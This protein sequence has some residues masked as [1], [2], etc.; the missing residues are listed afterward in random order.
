MSEFLRQF[1]LQIRYVSE[2]I[3]VHGD[4]AFDRG[5]YSQTL[6]PKGDGCDTQGGTRWLGWWSQLKSKTR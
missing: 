1:D 4:L 3:R 2:E 6:T 5:T